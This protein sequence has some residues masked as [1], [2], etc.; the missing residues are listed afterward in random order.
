MSEVWLF[1]LKPDMQVMVGWSQVRGKFY[2]ELEFYSASLN[3]PNKKTLIDLGYIA[4]EDLNE[5]LKAAGEHA[6]VPDDL[7]GFLSASGAKI[8]GSSLMKKYD[9]AN[10]TETFYAG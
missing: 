9:G 7:Y 6:K 3:S 8:N 1:P 2:V 5:I 4:H 10:E